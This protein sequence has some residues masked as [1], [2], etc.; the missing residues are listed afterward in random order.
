MVRVE[1]LLKAVID[2]P[3]APAGAVEAQKDAAETD[4]QHYVAFRGE[5]DAKHSRLVHFMEKSDAA[6]EKTVS[7][8]TSV[9]TVI[10][11]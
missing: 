5:M 6:G 1:N 9:R 2:S 3:D 8:D 11:R 10:F 4:A 7:G